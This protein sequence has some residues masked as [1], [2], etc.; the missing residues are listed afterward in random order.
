M[1]TIYDIIKE[2]VKSRSINGRIRF[3]SHVIQT[4]IPIYGQLEFGIIHTPDSYSRA[5][6]KI[7]EAKMFEPEIIINEEE[8]SGIG[9]K[10][11]Y[12]T[13]EWRV[14]QLNEVSA[15]TNN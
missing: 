2:W 1:K 3:A 8:G 9:K 11:K 12:Y 10:E 7:R 6:R 14:G 13:V 15:N 4:T 5:W